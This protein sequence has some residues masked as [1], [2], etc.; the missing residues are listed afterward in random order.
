MRF[1]IRKPRADIDIR[2]ENDSTR[3]SQFRLST[4]RLRATCVY[5]YVHVHMY[6]IYNVVSLAVN[7]FDRLR[8]RPAKI[9]LEDIDESTAFE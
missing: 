9:M 5:V 8:L 7:I 4:L 1:R 6:A 2:F 3:R